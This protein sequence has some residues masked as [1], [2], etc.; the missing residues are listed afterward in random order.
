MK[1]YLLNATL[2]TGK[3]LNCLITDI[4]GGRSAVSGVPIL[5]YPN[6]HISARDMGRKAKRLKLA[7]VIAQLSTP[8]GGSNVSV[9][10]GVT[11]QLLY[12]Q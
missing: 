5:T 10:V 1:Y 6:V 7:Y 4:A 11:A 3:D 12:L 2:N 8:I 9:I